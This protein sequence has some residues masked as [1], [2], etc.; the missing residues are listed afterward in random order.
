GPRRRMRRVIPLPRLCLALSFAAALA[1][2]SPAP[3]AAPPPTPDWLP[4]V[5]ALVAEHLA[6]PGAVGFSVGIAHRGH[7]LLEKGYGLAEVEHRV[8]ATPRTKFRIGSVTKQF[9]AALV[10][11]AVER[12]KVALDDGIEKCVPD[13]PLQGRHVTVRMLLDHTSGIRSYTDLGDEW[14]DVWPNELRHDQLLALVAGDPFDFEP[15]T[16]WHY[17]NTG[18]YLLGMLL[19]NVFEAPFGEL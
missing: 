11:R 7:V 18:Y 1:A 13:F 8:P 10:M 9:T 16:D 4:S 12:G 6:R 15:G 3:E 14:R 19:E 2:Q 5:D 17:N